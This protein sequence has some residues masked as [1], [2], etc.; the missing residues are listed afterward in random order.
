MLRPALKSEVLW[1]GVKRDAV[2]VRND[3]SKTGPDGP[4]LP[5]RIELEPSVDRRSKK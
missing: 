2:L 1:L 3:L 5:L 4:E